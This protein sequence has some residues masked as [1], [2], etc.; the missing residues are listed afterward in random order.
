MEEV[1]ELARSRDGNARSLTKGEAGAR[2]PVEHPGGNFENPPGMIVGTAAVKSRP[3]M[4]GDPADDGDRLTGPRVPR[5]PNLS[6]GTVG[7]A[8][9]GCTTGIARTRGSATF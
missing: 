5:I 8:L 3:A 1:A 7:I 9:C 6:R 2:R 4:P